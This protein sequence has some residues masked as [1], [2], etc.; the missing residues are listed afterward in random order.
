MFKNLLLVLALSGVAQAQTGVTFSVGSNPWNNNGM[1]WNVGVQ[2]YPGYNYNQGYNSYPVYTSP[3]YS[4]PV[5]NLPVAVPNYNYQ[6]IPPVYPVY[7]SYPV[8][9]PYYQHHRHYCR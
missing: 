4:V 2:S 1:Q 8:Y 7:N 9:L 3:G 5:Y 6:V